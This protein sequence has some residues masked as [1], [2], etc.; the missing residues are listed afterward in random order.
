MR[1]SILKPSGEHSAWEARRPSEIGRLN[2]G[3]FLLLGMGFW[4]VT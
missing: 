1:K 4:G 3:F 2:S